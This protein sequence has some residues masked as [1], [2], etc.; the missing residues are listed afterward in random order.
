MFTSSR[1]SRVLV[2]HLIYFLE[3]SWVAKDRQTGKPPQQAL[4]EARHKPFIQSRRS[5]WT[6]DITLTI[7]PQL[8]T[9]FSSLTMAPYCRVFKINTSFSNFS[10]LFGAKSSILWYCSS[11]VFDKN[12]R[13]LRADW[14]NFYGLTSFCLVGLLSI[15]T[16]KHGY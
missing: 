1:S 11:T 6:L 4:L 13:K 15:I 12:N 7:S 16:M 14:V 10:L 8:P 5:G 9:Y 2:C 3:Q